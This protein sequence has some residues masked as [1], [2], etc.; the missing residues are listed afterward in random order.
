MRNGN[1]KMIERHNSQRGWFAYELYQQMEK[2]P[3]VWVVTA[4]LGFGMLDHI[5]DSF[6]DR[7]I[8]VG[9]AEQT[10][11]GVAVGLA[12][13]HKKPFVYSITPF[14]L[15]RPYEAIKLYLDGDRYPVR[16]VGGGRDK[17][18]HIDGPSHDASDAHDLL[19]TLPHIQQ[20][21]PLDKEDVP[22]MVK[23]MV[24][25]DKPWFISL[26]R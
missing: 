21:W 18:Y 20:L 16:L 6:P 19:K 9:A 1:S 3:D 7:F 12:I 10:A 8:N 24:D 13:E 23:Y 14:L 11:I 17:D 4:D 22:A 26:K 15:R 2:D 25:V 5:R